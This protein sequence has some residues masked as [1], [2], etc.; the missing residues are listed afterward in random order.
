M[1][2][3]HSAIRF[4]KLF[5]CTLLLLCMVA[6]TKEDIDVLE[7]GKEQAPISSIINGRIQIKDVVYSRGILT[8]K[9]N[10]Q[11]IY[12]NT[13]TFPY[14]SIENGRWAINKEKTPV[15]AIYD[16]NGR[17]LFPSLTLSPEGFLLIDGLRTTFSWEASSFKTIINDNDW[18]WAVAEADSYLSFYRSNENVSV[19]PVI[20]SKEFIIPDYFFDLVV[21][22]EL[23]AEKKIREIPS[24]GSSSYV[25]FTDAHW[26]R[27]QKH[28]PAIIKHIEDYSPIKRV[29]FGG[30]V[31]TSH[32]D[33]AR[34]ALE[35]GEKFKNAFS[36]L[37]SNFYCLYGN[38][39]DNS[40]SQASLTE[41][42]LSDEQ[43]Y[44]Y[45][46]SQMSDV[47]Y[48]SYYNFY[49]DDTVSNTRFICL[50]TG[51]LYEKSFRS[52][53][54]ETAKFLIRCLNETPKGWHI[55]AASHIWANLKDFETGEMKESDYVRPIIEILENY[56]YRTKSS[57]SYAGQKLEYDFSSAE[58]TIEY[59]IGG[60]THADG[61]VLSKRGIPLIIVTCDGQKEVAGGAPYQTGTVNEQCVV[62]IVNDYLNRKVNLFHIGRGNDESVN[63]W[64]L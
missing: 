43:V 34:D 23:L 54:L 26:G 19:I 25:F 60:H 42:H 36:F 27:N 55:V 62:I 21:E 50:D 32:T 61:V 39:D 40:C 47:C 3:L 13:S 52:Y 7:F 5:S 46:Q 37:G 12:I 38:H 49:F 28:S 22:K 57:F 64:G 15:S 1:I 35:L 63:M 33:S 17:P 44:S 4:A 58:A 51:R 9:H 41:R 11:N 56:N 29:L 16:Q 30:D 59:C 31:I 6:C 10:K 24:G 2:F 14:L 18:I 20:E 48:E 45:L 8:I 53:S